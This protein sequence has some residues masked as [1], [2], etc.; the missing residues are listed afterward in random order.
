MQRKEIIMKQKSMNQKDKKINKS[1]SW[2]Y[3]KIISK[4][5]KPLA[6]SIKAKR[7]KLTV[8]GRKEHQCTVFRSWKEILIISCQYVWQPSEQYPW[9][10]KL[11]KIDPRRNRKCDQLYINVRNWIC[12][13]NPSHRG[14]SRSR[15]LQWWILWNI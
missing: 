15:R 9:E 14:N 13:W 2:L 5:Y 1:K 12:N 4:F 11:R 8:S 3:G 6:G 7:P 10:R